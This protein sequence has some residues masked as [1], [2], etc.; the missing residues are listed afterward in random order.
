MQ[1]SDDESGVYK[2]SA[3]G[4]NSSKSTIWGDFCSRIKSGEIIRTLAT[5]ANGYEVTLSTTPHTGEQCRDNDC[6]AAFRSI[7]D[8]CGTKGQN[9]DMLSKTGSFHAGCI[10]Y[11]YEVGKKKEDEPQK[12]PARTLCEKDSD[13]GK[14]T[15]DGG[16]KAHCSSQVSGD[17]LTKYCAC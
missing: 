4:P 16:K 13:C 7:M 15:C 2:A 6:D 9:K 1:C 8:T 11:G 14:W 17:P 3:A 10:E 5:E 12:P